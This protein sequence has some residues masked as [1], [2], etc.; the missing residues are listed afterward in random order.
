MLKQKI[1]P[2]NKYHNET[3]WLKYK[4]FEAIF[5]FCYI[6]VKNI[7]KLYYTD[8]HVGLYKVKIALEVLSQNLESR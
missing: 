6:Y 7:P 4:Y 5:K 2:K 8:I 1:R 3:F